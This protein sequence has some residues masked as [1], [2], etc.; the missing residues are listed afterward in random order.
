MEDA[1]FARATWRVLEPLHAVVYFAPDVKTAFED[2]GLHGFWRGYFAS[3]AAPMGPVPPE[4][5]IATFYNFHPDMVRWAMADAWQRAE[6]AAVTASRL[7]L[8]ERTLR[9]WLGEDALASPDVA[10][11]AAL[12][13]RMAEAASPLGRP[14]FAAYTTLDWPDEPHVILWHAATL[15]REHRGDGH[16]VTLVGEQI[17]GCEANVLAGASG[18][19]TGELQQAS[20]QWPD[21]E[22]GAATER[23]RLRGWIDTDSTLTQAGSAARG[24]LEDRTDELAAPPLAV[25]DDVER[26]RLLD[27]L[28]RLSRAVL[29]AGA[30]TFPNPIGLPDP[31]EPADPP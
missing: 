26:R 19:T 20:R 1:R 12:A 17:D 30:I 9:A 10:E 11:A 7:R 18:A 8:A 14:L 31:R 5:V 28:E 21:E 6:P 29:D 4:V 27:L 2:V 24:R 23:L 22:W 3:R 13:R 16:V 25:L 15:L